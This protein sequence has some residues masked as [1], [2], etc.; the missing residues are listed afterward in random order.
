VVGVNLA[1]NTNG[2]DW[3]TTAPFGGTG[4]FS[5]LDSVVRSA[6]VEGVDINLAGTGA[7]TL[8]FSLNNLTS[9]G[10]ALDIQ[11]TGTG[12][13]TIM[14]LQNNVVT[15]NTGGSGIVINSA[16][17]DATPG[18]A[19]QTV[20]G[21]T[22]AIG[23]SGNGVGG[24]GL[25]MTASG[26]LSFTDLDIFADGGTAF[27]LTGT[28]AVNTG[29]GTGTR[30]TVGA[31]VGIFEATG[32]PAVS[33]NNATIDLQLSSL[34]STNSPTTGVS[35]VN[36]DDGTTNAVFSAGSGSSIS[37]SSG[38]GF[39]VDQSNADV[40]YAGTL[41]TTAGAGVNLT[42][43]TAGTIDFTGTLTISSGSS[44][45]FNATGGGTISS[46]SAASTLTSTTGTALNVNATSI[47]SGGLV[48]T[49]I[50]ANGAAKGISLNSTGTAAGN[51]GLTVNGSGTTDGSGGVIQ[52]ISARG[53]EFI[54]TKALTLK[55]I[56]FTNA[57]TTDGGTCTDLSTAAC[58]AA[59]YLSGVTGVTLDN[60]NVTGTTSQEA[61]NG[62][63]VSTFS[64]NNS[65][66]ANCGTSGSIE[67]GCIKMREL[68][69]TCS[70]TGS[71]LNFP[72]QDVVEIVNTVGPALTLNVS[73]SQFRDSQSSSAGGN[74][75]QAR[76]QGTASMVLNITNNQF[77][78]L[79][80]N[81][82]Q[83]TA[84]NSASNDVDIT[85]NTFD[86]NTGTMIGIDLD[87]DNTGNL[88][89]NVQNNPKIY[90][91]NG[92]AV[93][94]FGDTNAVIN[95]R[96]SNN[97]DV[98]VKNNVGSNVGSGIR[99]NL[100]K[101]ATAKLEI[102]NNVVN[103]GSDDA[104]I[105]LSAIGKTTANPGG[106]T[107][108]LD[109][110]VTG[111]SVTIGATSTYGIIILSATNAA[112]NNALCA[113]VGTNA[114]TR[115]PS[116][117]ASF[118]ARVP[119]ATGFFRMNNFVTNAEATWNAKGNTPISAGGSEVSFGGSGTFAACTAALPTNPGPN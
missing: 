70:I 44:T 104:G 76:S 60:L 102:Q 59:I 3:T 115:N 39:L 116:S 88:V 46:T 15:G 30:V 43:N 56:N 6:G 64:L 35:L 114:I 27:G 26:D 36:A 81:G 54:T 52:N 109:A 74:G 87:A 94:V 69:G 4:T 18:G 82:V 96:I 41:N 5:I 53:A 107:N 100:N 13:L 1:G 111:N 23:A 67:E 45:A 25:A 49:S 19:Y 84:I 86:P 58:N 61:I 31:G 37:G 63:N 110:T 16:I 42:N 2:L 40:D 108:T 113:N 24:A 38:T 10:T 80:T 112:D 21:G 97:P 47:A 89:F 72:G 62:L 101:D 9:T 95:G 103:I 17:F 65:T 71:D 7:T 51:G 48:F 93:N 92:P 78:R 11:E 66:L 79:R 8:A 32:G 28:G 106:G 57:N 50:S 20:A 83:A 75:I 118:R 22:T 91:R 77:L 73:G 99:A 68:T 12:A 29:A 105:D 119:S 55:N 117:I 14:S 34:K 33:V 98:Q 90:S 85:N